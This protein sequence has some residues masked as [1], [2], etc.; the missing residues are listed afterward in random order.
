[1]F[2][3]SRLLALLIVLTITL[4]PIAPF[5]ESLTQAREQ[6]SVFLPIVSKGESVAQPPQDPNTTS[7]VDQDQDGIPDSFED[8]LIL[9]FAPVVKLH[10]EDVY[11]PA[12]VDWY[13]T[14]GT[15]LRFNRKKNCPDHEHIAPYQIGTVR[16]LLGRV[17]YQT[18]YYW[19]FCNDEDWQTSGPWDRDTDF[20]I[21]IAND[22]NESTT[23]RGNLSGAIAYAHVARATE[24]D[25]YDVSYYFFYAYNGDLYWGGPGGTIAGGSHE[26]DW[27][28]VTVRVR[29]DGQTIDRI[30]YAEHGKGHWY[31]NYTLWDGRPIVY[32]AWHSH[33]SYPRGGKWN[34]QPNL[35]DDFACEDPAGNCVT[36]DTLTGLTCLPEDDPD[37]CFPDDTTAPPHVQN[38]GEKNLPMPGMEWIRF[39]GRWGE[40]GAYGGTCKPCY[41]GPTTPSFAPDWDDPGAHPPVVIRPEDQSAD[42]GTPT[43]F[44]LGFFTDSAEDAGP[45]KVEVDWEDGFTTTFATDFQWEIPTTSHTYEEGPDV[46]VVNVMVQDSHG[47]W[48]SNFFEV[49]VNN[50]DPD[51]TIR[52]VSDEAGAR[53]GVDV[54]FAL[55]GLAV[56][57][58]ADF[59]DP[60]RFDVHTASVDWGDGSSDELGSLVSPVSAVHSYETP[61]TYTIALSVADDDGGVG[62]DNVSVRVAGSLEAIQTIIAELANIA[63][64]PDLSPESAALVEGALA[65]LRGEAG[66][67]AENGALDLLEKGNLNAALGRIRQ[68]LQLLEEAEAAHANLD[69]THTKG[70][71]TLTVK[72]VAVGAIAQAE[73]VATKS[74]EMEKIGQAKALVAQGDALLAAYDFVHSVAKYQEAVQKI[75]GIF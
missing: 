60:G 68:A 26:G 19:P 65:K 70:L 3:K 32:S 66:G 2:S 31:G 71:L 74:K 1:M 63:A 28:R 16:N 17:D 73:A 75:Q 27:E 48:G 40:I 35:P 61:G 36:W 55:V 53:I 38:I 4:G 18:K 51:V 21:Q 12:S 58:A 52:R 57:L 37:T 49:I 14:Q 72:S 22:A 20:F 30:N 15:T 25:K 62:T 29:D 41:S 56:E 11:Q 44:H 5:G 10:I 7:D 34:R 6:K 59:T 24:I 69:L 46:L 8:E 13:L 67:R 54:P 50:V 33:A 9:R 43:D 23:R 42:E 47:W 64:D 39:T 45:W